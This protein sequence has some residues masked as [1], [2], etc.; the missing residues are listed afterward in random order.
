MI[1]SFPGKPVYVLNDY[2]KKLIETEDKK[3]MKKFEQA[4]SNTKTVQE[5]SKNVLSPKIQLLKEQ[6]KLLKESLPN[7]AAKKTPVKDPKKEL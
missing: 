3:R 4:K 5:K 1:N 7:N 2:E 6:Q